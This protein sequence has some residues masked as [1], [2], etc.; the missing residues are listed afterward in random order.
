MG[1]TWARLWE[2]S[3]S[4]IPKYLDHCVFLNVGGNHEISKI[5]NEFFWLDWYPVF[6]ILF[7]NL[8]S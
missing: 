2:V 1:L 6:S 4:I 5:S 7:H 8:K 3:E